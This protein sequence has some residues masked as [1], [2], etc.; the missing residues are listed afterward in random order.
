V[1][2]LHE[3]A[4]MR[5]VSDFQHLSLGQLN[6]FEFHLLYHALCLSLT[7]CVFILLR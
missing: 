1:L 5:V 2:C 7:L 6:R 3:I 4:P